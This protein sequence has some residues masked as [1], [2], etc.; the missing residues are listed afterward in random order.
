[1]AHAASGSMMF[2]RPESAAVVHELTKRAGSTAP[3]KITD[4]TV[5]EYEGRFSAE[6][7]VSFMLFA[8][9]HPAMFYLKGRGCTLT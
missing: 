9:Q 8:Q 1:M 6:A 5:T 3:F 2:V 4:I 7:R